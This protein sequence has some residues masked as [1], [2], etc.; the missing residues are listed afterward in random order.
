MIITRCSVSVWFNLDNDPYPTF[1]SLFA[2]YIYDI[3][4]CQAKNSKDAS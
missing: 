3:N 4:I 2:F 1:K